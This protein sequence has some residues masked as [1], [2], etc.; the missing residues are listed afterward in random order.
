MLTKGA[1]L[2]PTS[3]IPNTVAP[4]PSKTVVCTHTHTHLGVGPGDC[5]P[6]LYEFLSLEAPTHACSFSPELPTSSVTDTKLDTTPLA[7]R[8]PGGRGVISI[9]ATSHLGV[10]LTPQPAWPHSIKIK[11]LPNGSPRTH[12]LFTVLIPNNCPEEREGPKRAGR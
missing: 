1:R 6:G 12:F 8:C 4:W 10:G 9:P 7:P 11:D 3:S 2:Y 5:R